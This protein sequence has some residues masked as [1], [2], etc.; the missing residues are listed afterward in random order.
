MRSFTAILVAAASLQ[1]SLASPVYIADSP[2]PTTPTAAHTGYPHP[3][4]TGGYIAHGTGKPHFSWGPWIKDGDQSGVPYPTDHHKTRH[5]KSHH[6]T[7]TGTSYPTNVPST[8]DGQK[9]G[10]EGKPP[11]IYGT[12]GF[13][14]PLRLH[15]LHP[16]GQYFPRPTGYSVLGGDDKKGQDGGV[17]HPSGGIRHPPKH[18]DGDGEGKGKQHSSSPSTLVPTATATVTSTSTDES[19]DGSIQK[20]AP[21]NHGPYAFP[22]ASGGLPWTSLAIPTFPHPT[23]HHHLR[24]TGYPT[25]VP[26]RYHGPPPPRDGVPK[27]DGVDSPTW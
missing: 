6:H 8:G 3:H 2:P 4:P 1:G 21:A 23:A 17:A 22:H 20:R 27:E 14:P 9:G 5:H 11:V 24:P 19:T 7:G 18:G 16:T 25:G 13:I 26:F 15:S 10:E 12:G